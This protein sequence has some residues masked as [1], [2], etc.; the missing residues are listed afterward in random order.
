MLLHVLITLIAIPLGIGVAVYGEN[1]SDGPAD[2]AIVLGFPPRDLKPAPVYAE[3]LNQGIK[4]IEGN[5]VQ[6]LIL[7]GGKGSKYGINEADAGKQY[8][9]DH[10]ISEN[11]I[12]LEDSS[13]TTF[14]NLVNARLVMQRHNFHT[15]LIVSDPY[16]M[17]RA[18]AMCHKL[19]IDAQPSPTQTS[20][21]KSWFAKVGNAAYEAVS[22]AIAFFRGQVEL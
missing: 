22:L 7:T 13:T 17:K 6:Y 10:G 9:L 11:K 1:Y 21:I 4:L 8:M 16:H 5:H 14:E 19:G 20:Y 12:L 3:R 2:V 15:A 18:M